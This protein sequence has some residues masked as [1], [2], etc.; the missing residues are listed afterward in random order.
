M[1]RGGKREGAGRKA[2]AVAKID[3]DA[4]DKAIALGVKPLEVLLEMMVDEPEH[5]AESVCCQ[6]ATIMVPGG[7]SS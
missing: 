6:T 1:A 2:G 5:V 4:R 7:N 3:Q